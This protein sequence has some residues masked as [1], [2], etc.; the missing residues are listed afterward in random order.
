VSS[1]TTCL[2]SCSHRLRA[3]DR[4]FHERIHSLEFD[5]CF[6]FAPVALACTR[7]WF[8]TM[9]AFTINIPNSHWSDMLAV[10]AHIGFLTKLGNRY[11]VTLPET[12]DSASIRSALLRLASTQDDDTLKLCYDNN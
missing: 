8:R 1:G 11:Q 6:A 9:A 2:L 3:A 10:L 5:L 12:L 4:Y 7:K